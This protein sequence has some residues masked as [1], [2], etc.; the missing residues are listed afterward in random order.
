[1]ATKQKA[2]GLKKRRRTPAES[3]AQRSRSYAN[4]QKKRKIHAQKHPNDKA[5]IANVK[6]WTP[7]SQRGQK[8]VIS[9]LGG[10]SE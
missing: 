3:S 1:M 10:K 5:S 9:G 7:E 4:K 6:R 8:T 2:G